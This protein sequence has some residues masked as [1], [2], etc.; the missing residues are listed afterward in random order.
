MSS[1]ETY[2]HTHCPLMICAVQM[3]QCMH[4]VPKNDCFVK[5][6]KV[7]QLFVYPHAPSMLGFRVAYGKMFKTT[8]V[9]HDVKYNV[10]KT[11]CFLMFRSI[12]LD[13]SS[14]HAQ[15]AGWAVRLA[16]DWLCL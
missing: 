5:K 9:F 15:M 3:P 1:E 13:D 4:D 7:F 12:G 6:R 8:N 10:S 2:Q 11:R 14:L 16:T